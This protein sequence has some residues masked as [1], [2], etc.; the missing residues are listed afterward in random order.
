MLVLLAVALCGWR[1]RVTRADYRLGRGQEA[2]REGDWKEAEQL[3]HRLEATGHPDHAHLLRG[4]LHFARKQPELALAEM[5]QIRDEGSIRLRA[6][7]LTGR[8]LL[9]L[10]AN[11]EAERVFFFVINQ[12]PDN[13]DAHRGLAAIG[14]DLAQTNRVIYHLKEVMRL[15]PADARPHRMLAEVTDEL[16]VTI[17]EYREALRLRNGLSDTALEEVW[18]SLAEALI[19]DTNFA[20]AL[21]TIEAAPS[22]V[23]ESTPM[24]ALKVEALRGVG[25]R[26]EA[27]ALA[28]RLLS[29]SHEGA[30]YRL[31]GQLYLEE[32]NAAAALPLLEEA[33]RLSPR[34]YQSHFLLAQAYA[35]TG[36]NADAD[37]SN[38]VAEGI[39]KDYELTTTLTR[40]ALSKPWD[41]VVRL[42][43]A[44][45]CERTGDTESAETWRKAARQCQVRKN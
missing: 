7:V 32:D 21:A 34:H 6:A 22:G 25:R 40:E 4:E 12:D 15:D 43:L 20:D 24:L 28:D 26:P 8:C 2:V 13:L 5:N 36:R 18:F 30:V 23:A 14:H 3:A 35:A 33:T 19:R 10:G 31:R 45:V 37:R 39:R 17:A 38:A 41:P 16:E 11:N 29:L 9:D 1:Y 44:E 27:I 42:K